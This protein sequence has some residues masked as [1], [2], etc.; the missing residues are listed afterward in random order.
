MWIIGASSHASLFLHVSFC[1]RNFCSCFPRLAL[2]PRT[3]KKKSKP[4]NRFLQIKVTRF[5]I[6][7][8][9]S[10]SEWH[11]EKVFV[12]ILC[13]S[14]W[15][16]MSD[17]A[18]FESSRVVLRSGAA[19]CVMHQY[20]LPYGQLRSAHRNSHRVDEGEVENQRAIDKQTTTTTTNMHGN[21]RQAHWQMTSSEPQ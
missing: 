15:C 21:K 12:F 5:D 9:P 16:A 6:K 14:R 3:P 7:R 2:P 13:C 8:N 10:W 20:N 4:S 17:G 1:R 18:R 11:A 19:F